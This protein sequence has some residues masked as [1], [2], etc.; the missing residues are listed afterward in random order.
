MKDL[1]DK[2]DTFFKSSAEINLFNSRLSHVVILGAITEAGIVGKYCSYLLSC[3]SSE[4]SG[5]IDVAPYRYK[6]LEERAALMTGIL[7]RVVTK[8]SYNFNAII[9]DMKSRGIDP[10]L[11]DKFGAV[12]ITTADVSKTS[13][14]VRGFLS[15]N[16]LRF[17]QYLGEKYS[18]WRHSAYQERKT[19]QDWMESHVSL[20]KM[21]LD[22]VSPET[23]EY[24]RLVGIIEKY[25]DMINDIARANQSYEASN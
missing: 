24:K 13:P 18:A 16:P 9:E 19:H 8:T 3:L 17:F 21:K 7:D 12:D 2:L 15:V 22:G 23:P 14:E 25:E 20:L 1:D 4:I 6:Y 10:F 11:L 5:D